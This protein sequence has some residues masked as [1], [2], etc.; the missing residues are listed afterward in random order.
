MA[1]TLHPRSYNAASRSE[2]PARPLTLFH[3]L[4]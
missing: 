4:L 1:S 3:L 2:V